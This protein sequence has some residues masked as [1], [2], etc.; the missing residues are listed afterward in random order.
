MMGDFSISMPHALVSM[1]VLSVLS[2][3]PRILSVDQASLELINIY[4]SLPGIEAMHYYAQ[5][6]ERS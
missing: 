6:R 1:S 4:P 5:L 2:L 3:Y